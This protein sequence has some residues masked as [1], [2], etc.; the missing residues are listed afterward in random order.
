MALEKVDENDEIKKQQLNFTK[1]IWSKFALQ[2]D[3]KQ[4]VSL[5][6]IVTTK[7]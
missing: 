7:S 2:L 5:G 1:K 6:T 3:W 4:G